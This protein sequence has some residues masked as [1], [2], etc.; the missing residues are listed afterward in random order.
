MTPAAIRTVTM[1]D[2]ELLLAWRNDEET[3]QMSRRVDRIGPNEHHAWLA[4]ALEDPDRL[5]ALFLIDDEPVASVR[6]D[7][8]APDAEVSITVAPDRR[9]RGVAS[10]ALRAA[11]S[12]LRQEWPHV[13]ALV[14]I[15]HVTNA[16]SRRLF[17]RDGYQLDA[18]DGRWLTLRKTIAPPR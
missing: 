3:R 18:R 17:E 11:E 10:L 16:P 2:A 12:A 14:A 7:R 6:Y 15:V 4:S 13:E 8:Q 5:L 1:D 9:G